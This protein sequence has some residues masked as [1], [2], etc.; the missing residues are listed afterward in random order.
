MA[1]LGLYIGLSFWKSLQELCYGILT[2]L[3]FVGKGEA[4]GLLT[5]RVRLAQ[6][7]TPALHASN[8][9]GGFEFDCTTSEVRNNTDCVGGSL[10]SKQEPSTLLNQELLPGRDTAFQQAGIR[11]GKLLI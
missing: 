10:L 6:A 8:T 9:V 2:S 4:G 1:A 11:V 5:G 3:S 7:E